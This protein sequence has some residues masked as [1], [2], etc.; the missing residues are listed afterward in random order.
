MKTRSLTASF[1]LSA[2]CCI[3]GLCSQPARSQSEVFIYRPVPA[4]PV[5]ELQQV[6]ALQTSVSLEAK[7]MPLIGLLAEM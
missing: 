3:G 1:L 4:N 2:S 5:P 6:T 7:R